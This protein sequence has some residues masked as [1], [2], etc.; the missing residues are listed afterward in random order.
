MP[1]ADHPEF[2]KSYTNVYERTV[3]P[4]HGEWQEPGCDSFHDS[5]CPLCNTAHSPSYSID[6]RT[7]ERI[8]HEE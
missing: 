2:Q 3:D 7:G 6:E 5:K 8:S 1:K 4:T